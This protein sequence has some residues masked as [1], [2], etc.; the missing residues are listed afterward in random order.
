MLKKL[1]V[2]LLVAAMVMA[3]VACGNQANT[4][5]S[6]AEGNSTAGSQ[7]ET[8]SGAEKIVLGYIGPVTGEGAPWGL[9]E[10]QTF[11]ML[12][13]KVNKE[14]GIIGKQVELKIY[15]TAG[16][17]VQTTNAARKAI[18]NDGVVAFIGPDSSSS[19]LALAE[20]CDEYG[21]PF[22]A[23]CATNAK[24]TQ[25]EDGTVR[26]NAFRA[27]LSDPQLNQVLAQYAYNELNIKTVAIIYNIGDDYCV[28]CMQNFDKAFT[29]CGG[30]IVA[31][32]AYQVGDVD[33][34]AQLTNISNKEFDAMY[35]PA[36]YKELGLIAN[37]SRA[38]GIDETFIGP[39]CWLMEDLF[40]IASE[41]MEGGTFIVGID[42][43][44]SNLQT[45]KDEFKAI[46]GYDPGSVGADAFF[47]YDCFQVIKN[48][49]ETKNSAASADIRDAMENTKD[50]QC[51]TSVLS[52]NPETHN[53]V[54]NAIICKIES[55]KFVNVDT[56]KST[57]IEI[58]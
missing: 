39:D 9:V 28:G 3:L 10:S 4:T 25:L 2:I 50:L 32:E 17:A 51:L 13:D 35:I 52:I 20:V 30:K 18:Q 49:I 22:M 55:S 23:T 29:A 57:E 24:V 46:Y 19:A 41:S 26:P 8:K 5:A 44:A 47:T 14:G 16:D 54:R 43:E 58:K 31:T 7:S 42:T 56:F 33:F 15:D 53:P 6:T 34:R 1:T 48:A 36:T 21:V 45:F 27:C 37:Q 40:S 12:V 11:E 38:L